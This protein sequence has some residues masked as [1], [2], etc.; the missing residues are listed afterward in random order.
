MVYEQPLRLLEKRKFIQFS[1][2]VII[3]E[4]I[5]QI[6]KIYTVLEVSRT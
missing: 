1:H 6:Y 2:S 3:L 4:Y 5:R